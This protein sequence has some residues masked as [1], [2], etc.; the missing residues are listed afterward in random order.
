MAELRRVVVT[1]LGALTPIGN[2]LPE[3]WDALEKG[4]SGAARI[5]YFDPSKFRSH[6]ACEVK[7]FNAEQFIDRKE[8]RKMDP[9]SQ[10]AVVAS[11][12][13]IRD[14]GLKLET[15]D[16]KERAGVIWGTGIGGLVTFQEET[17]NF[18]RGDG[19]PRFN[20]FF[21]PKMI[22]DSSSGSL[23]CGTVYAGRAM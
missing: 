2:T 8:A 13:A 11:D 12:E 9:F 6:F 10:F 17:M 5:T 18:A 23:A 19:N 1:G 20:P 16:E 7:G 3:Y 4:V 22:A 21:I 14:S 15:D